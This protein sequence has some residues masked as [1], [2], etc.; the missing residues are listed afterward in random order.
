MTTKTLNK[1]IGAAVLLCAAS[2][3][4]AED[5][6]SGSIH[7][8]LVNGGHRPSSNYLSHLHHIQDMMDLMERRGVAPERVRQP[9]IVVIRIDARAARKTATASSTAPTGTR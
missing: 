2:I 3:A 1:V 6:T 8:L 9:P 7:A 4:S 5:T